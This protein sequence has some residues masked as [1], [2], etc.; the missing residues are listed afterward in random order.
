[1]MANAVDG[2]HTAP[3]QAIAPMGDSIISLSLLEL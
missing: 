1:M 3:G 2:P